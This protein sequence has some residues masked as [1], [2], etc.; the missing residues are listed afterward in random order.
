MTHEDFVVELVSFCNLRGFS[1][2]GTCHS[3]GIFGEILIVKDGDPIPWDNWDKNKYNFVKHV[4]GKWPQP[5]Y[6]VSD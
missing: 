4:E 2:A 3:E 5:L 1:I 6:V